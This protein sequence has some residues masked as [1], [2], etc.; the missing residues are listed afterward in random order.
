[1]TN[2]RLTPADKDIRLITERDWQTFVIQLAVARKW[3]YYHPPDNKPINGRIQRVVAGFPDLVLIK[4]GRM[5]YAELKREKGI[6]SLEQAEWIKEIKACGI[7][8]YVWRPSQVASVIKILN[9]DTT[10]IL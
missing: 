9:G 1:M 10:I 3:K 2:K 8:C 5:V 4:D 6:I 7:E